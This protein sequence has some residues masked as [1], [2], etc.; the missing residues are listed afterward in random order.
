MG[1]S[2]APHLAYCEIIVKIRK[3]AHL[4]VDGVPCVEPSLHLGDDVISMS[5]KVLEVGDAVAR[6]KR[7]CH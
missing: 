6:E 4:E 7:T 5:G 3:A 2:L 1:P